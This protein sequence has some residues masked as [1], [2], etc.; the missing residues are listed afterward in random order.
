MAACDT[1]N[2]A[3]LSRCFSCLNPVQHMEVQTYLL[4]QLAGM[5]SDPSTLI[6]AAREFGSIPVP[7]LQLIKTYLLCSLVSP[8]STCAIDAPTDLIVTDNP[9]GGA[10]FQWNYTGLPEMDFLFVWGT[11]SGGPYDTGSTTITAAPFIVSLDDL[12]EGTYY[13]VVY[14]RDSLTCVSEASNEVTWSLP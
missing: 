11:N 9:P 13:A 5:S 7:I 14:A 12:P 8:T 1:D 2:L 3:N 6:Q 10:L 4:A